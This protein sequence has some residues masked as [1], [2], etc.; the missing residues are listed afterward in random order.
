MI[1]HPRVGFRNRFTALFLC[2]ALILSVTPLRLFPGPAKA[3]VSGGEVLRRQLP[4]YSDL[5]DIGALLNEGKNPNRVQPRQP[6]LKRPTLCGYRDV[7]CRRI[8]EKNRIGRN[9][10]PS[11]DALQLAAG[12]EAEQSEARHWAPVIFSIPGGE[13]RGGFLKFSGMIGNSLLTSGL[14][15][16]TRHFVRPSGFANPAS[17]PA[18]AAPPSFPS[19]AAAKL[20]PRYRVGEQGEDL[21]SGNFHFGLPLVSLPGRSGMDLNLTLSYNSLVWIK[22]NG[23]MS[24]D[25]DHNPTLT[26]GFRLGLPELDGSHA[27]NGIAHY[28][29][30]LPSGKRVGLQEIATN[31]YEA[32]DSSYLFLRVDPPSQTMTLYTPDGTQFL[33]SV[34]SGESRYRCTQIKDRNGNYL[35]VGYTTIGTGPDTLVVV[36]SI[37]DTLGR[38]INFNYDPETLHLLTI[39]QNW[40]SQTRIWAQFDYGTLTIQTNFGSLTVDGPAN[41]TQIPVITRVITGDGA[42]H[43]LVYNSW[44]QVQDIWRYGEADNQRAAIDYVFPDASAP[45]SDCPRYFQRNDYAANWAGLNWTGWVSSY[46]NFDPNEAYGQVTTPDGV[47]YKEL[48]STS[49]GTRGLT[50]RTET[51][52]NGAIQKFTD[53]TWASDSSVSPPL[54]P[55]VTDIKICDDLNHNGTYQSGTDKLRRTAISYI[56]VTAT[57]KLPHIVSEYNE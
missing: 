40:Q 26:P 20:D 13:S 28:I 38:V 15:Q 18:M 33:Y 57:A 12:Q 48:F 4:P 49:G 2:S 10:A 45:L 35:T 50:V 29:V 6:P 42:R 47:T 31:Q 55:R 22:Y 21:F 34:P 30:T 14:H 1:G 8:K 32:T 37:T 7:V 5:P 9:E 3:Q 36:G 56:S 25:Y 27:V 53:L 52:H 39:T 43:T 11:N 16:I 23:I 17:I 54:R 24:F 51:W 41:S 19:L 46:F 44:G